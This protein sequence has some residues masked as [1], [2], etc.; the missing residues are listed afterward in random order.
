MSLV[1]LL[2][3]ST[4]TSNRLMERPL[5]RTVVPSRERNGPYKNSTSAKDSASRKGSSNSPVPCGRVSPHRP[6][7]YRESAEN[8]LNLKTVQRIDSNASEIML[9]VAKV[10]VYE[11]HVPND[12]W[13]RM[14]S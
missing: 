8:S 14:F 10:V 1:T 3:N 13:V 6:R 9:R 2:L 5:H 11:Y 4:P 7:N 12:T